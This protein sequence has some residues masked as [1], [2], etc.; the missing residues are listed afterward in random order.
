MKRSMFR[1]AWLGVSISLLLVGSSPA[2]SHIIFCNEFTQEIFVA[3]AYEQFDRNGKHSGWIGRGWLWLR[4]GKCNDFDSAL[5]VPEF[6]WRAET[7][8]YQV[9]DK[10]HRY[11]WPH[12]D[13]GDKYFWDLTE[14]FNLYDTDQ[15][16]TNSK[17]TLSAY[18]KSALSANG[19]INVEYTFTKDAEVSI[20]YQGF[21]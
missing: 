8:L 14:D 12:A 4:P 19:P 16:P 5:A 10:M 3:I 21:K 13:G 15:R 2:S 18:R 6:Y 20:S 7:N 11:N 9:G 17:P 1:V